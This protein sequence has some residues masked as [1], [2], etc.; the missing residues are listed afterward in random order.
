MKNKIRVVV[1]GNQKICIACVRKLLSLP[2]VKL[3]A[4]VGSE[5]PRDKQFGYDSISEYCKKNKIKFYNPEKLTEEFVEKIKAM[6]PDICFSIYYRYIFKSNLITLPKMGFLNIH[7]SLLPT[8]RG[9][10]P[11]MW[12]LLRGEK[13]VGTTIHYIDKGVD[14]GDIVAQK[15]IRIPAGI[16]GFELNE[17]VMNEGIRLFK[18]NIKK[19]LDG[20]NER[21]VQNP[22]NASYF[23][24][25]V[26]SVSIIDWF[27]KKALIKRKVL[28]L[29]KP[30]GG[31]V[32][33]INGKKIIVW[34]VKILRAPLVNAGGPGRILK[35]YPN[36]SFVV[37][38]VDGYI[39]IT[40]FTLIRV[41]PKNYGK[42]I[43]IGNKLGL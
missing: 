21:Y 11:T 40:K 42:Y 5:L 37:T 27:S 13:Y 41:A 23:G 18:S 24:A 22:E 14:T 34:E 20:K 39:K 43:M 19:I 32:T 4:V 31:A 16:T 7:P 36:G 33:Y 8:Y 28:A 17:L 29:T 10:A 12:S 6:K 35:V 25:F 1:F 15:R 38:A 9:P 2:N 26:S 30:Y 3:C